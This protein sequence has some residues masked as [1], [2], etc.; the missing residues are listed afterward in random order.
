MAAVTPATLPPEVSPGDRLSFTL[1]LAVAIH[2]ALILGV[3][4]TYVTSKPST[5]TM[6]VTL[7]QQRS[8]NRPDKADF[9][10]QVNQTGSGTLEEKALMTSPTEARFQDTE[11][12][13]EQNQRINENLEQEETFLFYDFSGKVL[14]DFNEYHKIR[15]SFIAIDN[16]LDFIET[17]TDTD[18]TSR[19]YLDQTNLSAGLQWY[20]TWSDRFSTHANVYF[21]KY[22]LDAQSFFPNQIQRL[23]Q[24]NIVEERAIKLNA[25]FAI[26][27]FISWKN[28][29][30]YIETGITNRAINV[31][32]PFNGN[33]KD[34]IRV[35]A[36]YTQLD[37]MTDDN[38]FFV[39]AGLRANYI[40]NLASFGASFNRLLFEPR[41][42]I[43]FRMA[44]Y[45][46]AQIQGEFKSQ[47]TNQVID[48][49]QNFLGV[50]KRRWTLSN[51]DDLPLTQSKQGSIGINYA[52]NQFYLGLEADFFLQVQYI[53]KVVS[54]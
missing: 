8:K 15:L 37:I 48:L 24:R 2:A 12:R 41:L 49:E 36:P 1:F 21:S 3:T 51:E 53:S 52:K 6:E 20:G 23:D 30:Q 40:E 9:L 45:L 5:H 39:S 32:P 54:I 31:Q 27:E 46:R 13:N 26:S 11:I 7:A 25:N 42:N 18:E 16:D 17:D 43:N 14:Y 28:G 4:F 22:D 33:S 50:E 35:Q 44:N 19:S 34:I 29:Y 38:V 47:S 10:A